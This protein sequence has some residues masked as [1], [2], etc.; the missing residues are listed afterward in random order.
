MKKILK[1]LLIREDEKLTVLYFLSFFFIVGCGLATGKASAEALFFKRYG[2]EYLPFMYLALGILLAFVSLVYA[3]FAD[4]IAAEKFFIY[5]FIILAGTLFLCWFFINQ[6]EASSIYPVYFLV[7]EVASEL[8]ILHSAIYISQNFDSFKSKRLSPVILSGSLFGMITGGILVAIIAPVI[9]TENIILGWLILLS[10]TIILI[11]SW[12]VFNGRSKYFFRQPSTLSPAN[13]IWQIKQG[14]YFSKKSTL[15]SA[16]LLS[17]FFLVITFY[18]LHFVTN[19]IYTDYFHSEE[20]LTAFFGILTAVTSILGLLLQLFITNRAVQK[21][22]IPRLNL[23]FPSVMSLSFALLFLFKLPA[24]LFG[25]FVK[26]SLH[27]ALNTPLRNMILNILPKNI[28]GRIRAVLLGV[29][30]PL[31]LIICSA[32]LLLAQSYHQNALFLYAGILTS[33]TM[34][35]LSFKVS[36]NYLSTLI[37][38]L[39]EQVFLPED[40]LNQQKPEK[41]LQEFSQHIEDNDD[42]VISYAKILLKTHPEQ[43]SKI[44]QHHLPALQENTAQQLLELISPDTASKVFSDLEYSANN[45]HL[46]NV[47]DTHIFTILFNDHNQA[48]AGFIKPLMESN[49]IEKNITG[50]YGAMSMQRHT[51]QAATLWHQLMSSGHQQECLILT[52]YIQYLNDKIQSDITNAY[53]NYFREELTTTDNSKLILLLDT[54]TKWPLPISRVIQEQLISLQKNSLAAIRERLIKCSHLLSQEQ[55]MMLLINALDDPHITVRKAAVS[56]LLSVH[57]D[58]DQ[59]AIHWLIEQNFLSIR[60]QLT[61]LQYLLDAGISVKTILSVTQHCIEQTRSFYDAVQLLKPHQQTTADFLLYT[62]LYERL[63]QALELLLNLLNVSSQGE[64][65]SVIQAA[66]SSKDKLLIASASEALKCLDNTKVSELIIDILQDDFE[67]KNNYS[68]AF[69]NKTEVLQWCSQQDEWLQTCATQAQ[70]HA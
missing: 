46:N 13:A 19:S 4:Q 51:D 60:S 45:N 22:G 26:D 48:A 11:T 37:L 7:Y 21:F 23:L 28:Q 56:K 62:T 12:H 30:L 43:T 42:L 66:I 3:S 6:L 24:A 59:L 41:L 40:C 54:L 58:N 53:Q 17:F 68:L 70:Q 57:E 33:L 64:L 39:K 15:L 36:R 16:S 61:L 44:I 47:L 29:V 65:V 18:I 55:L 8:I 31:A 67:L 10:I 2:I 34:L 52:K 35:L 49:D 9:G 1:L 50:I 20:T 27:P 5:L 63:Q 14:L 32:I 69:N 25:S 38:H